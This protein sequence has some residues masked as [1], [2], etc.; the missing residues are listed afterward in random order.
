MNGVWLQA[1]LSNLAPSK[2]FPE[3]GAGSETRLRN[4]N[5]LVE[6]AGNHGVKIYLYMNEPRTMPAEFFTRHPEIKG[7]HDPGDEQFFTMCTSTP[8]VREWLRDSLA[9]LFSSVP[10]LG[11]IFSITASENLTN[12]SPAATRSF[13][14]AARSA[15]A[16]RW[17]WK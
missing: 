14:R 15:T 17:S 8:E 5:K 16:Q 1:V 11:E 3:S 10:G 7:T 13:A 9:H 2:R 4:L 6:R 12:V